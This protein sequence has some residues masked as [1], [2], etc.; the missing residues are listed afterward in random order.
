MGLDWV[1]KLDEGAEKGR[2]CAVVRVRPIDSD[3][4]ARTAN[5]APDEGRTDHG[6]VVEHY[7][8]QH[9]DQSVGKIKLDLLT[10]G[11][12]EVGAWRGMRAWRFVGDPDGTW[13][14][15]EEEE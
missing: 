9:H 5:T 10:G 1:L 11:S 14:A 4:Q 7:G 8:D 2:I 15:E 12:I 3:E 6:V 13:H